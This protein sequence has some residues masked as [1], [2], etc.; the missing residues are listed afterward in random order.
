MRAKPCFSLKAAL[1][2]SLV[3]LM[4]AALIGLIGSVVIFQVFAVFEGQKRTTTSGG[5]AQ[6][7]GALA[8]FTVERDLRMAGYGIN[9]LDFLGCTIRGWDEQTGGGTAFT[10]TL[11]PV[12]IKPSGAAAPTDPPADPLADPDSDM[13]AVTYGTGELL[14][15]PASITQNMPSPSSDF[16]VNNRYGFKEGDLVIAAEAGK[17]CTLAQVSTLPGTPGQTDN[18][19]HN[20]GNYTDPNSGA[21]VATRYNKP[22]GLGVSYGTNG[23]LFNLGA[24]PSSNVYSVRSG[25][26]MLQ[27]RLSAASTAATPIYDGIV[28]MRAQYGKDTSVPADGIVD[29]VDDV[30]P[31]NAAGW[32]QVLV[33]RI[34][35]VARSSQYE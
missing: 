32:A 17:D 35:I 28:K 31:V 27:Q 23:K 14:P 1:G 15:N 30:T 24:L 3:E 5:D 7:N 33:M 13:I 21:Q 12:V 25:Q 10:L 26:L 19:I 2:M 29:V 16:K 6:T 18:V 34:A 8:L 9:N 4:V 22:A 20:S 11:V